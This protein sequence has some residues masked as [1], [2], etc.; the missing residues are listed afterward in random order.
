MWECT[1][2][3]AVRNALALN[4]LLPYARNHLRDV[5][6]GPLRACCDHILYIVRLLER[7]LCRCSGLV[8]CLV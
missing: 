1:I 7:L 2:K 6:E 8:A 4:V 5:D 3:K